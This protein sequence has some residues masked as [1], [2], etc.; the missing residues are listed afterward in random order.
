MESDSFTLLGKGRSDDVLTE[1]MAYFLIQEA[2]TDNAMHHPIYKF[3]YIF[4]I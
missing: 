1:F 4:V 2:K 3:K